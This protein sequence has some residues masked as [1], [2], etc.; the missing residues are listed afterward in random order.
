M[1]EQNS[2][3]KQI[4]EALR[5]MNDSTVEVQKSSKDMSAQN[6]HVMKEMGILQ[7][8]TEN[9]KLSMEEMAA[10][11]RKINET[12]ATLGTISQTVQSSITKI[13]DQ[14]DLFKV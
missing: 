14:I 3:S 5:N 6:E 8:V 12:G 1:E 7:D 10:G 9:M 13:G 11:A 4:S 2:G